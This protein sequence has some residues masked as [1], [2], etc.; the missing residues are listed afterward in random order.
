M[1]NFY[2]PQMPRA[3]PKRD[4]HLP[5]IGRQHTKHNLETARRKTLNATQLPG[6]NNLE[7]TRCAG[8]A[9]ASPGAV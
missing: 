8:H 6:H 4:R 3:Q 1:A 7:T 2:T 9:S 5:S